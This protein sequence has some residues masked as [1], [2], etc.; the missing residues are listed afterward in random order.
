MDCPKL[1]PYAR[2][3]SHGPLFSDGAV[4][5]CKPMH[6]QRKF[7]VKFFKKILPLDIAP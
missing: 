1:D 5:P 6:V 2:A 7:Q 4:I 3:V